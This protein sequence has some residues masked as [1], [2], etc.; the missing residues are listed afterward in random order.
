VIKHARIKLPT[1]FPS[2]LLR[3]GSLFSVHVCV[4]VCFRVCVHVAR[5]YP[6][7]GSLGRRDH[8]V[9]AEGFAFALCACNHA[10]GDSLTLIKAML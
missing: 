2:K 8:L 5:R 4:C 1:V 7:A 10:E 3:Y 9:A 6:S